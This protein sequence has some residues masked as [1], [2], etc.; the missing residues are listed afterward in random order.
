MS[1]VVAYR[2]KLIPVDLQ[3]KE[4][5]RWIQDRLRASFLPTDYGS[6]LEALEDQYYN[7]Y[8]YDSATETLYA[9]ERQPL[10]PETFVRSTRNSDGSYD[11][12]LS[13]HSGIVGFNE[14]AESILR[15]A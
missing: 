12:V 14:V 1:K 15:P 5:D 3:G 6:W 4:L 7:G 9:V 13:Y 8:F 11:F 10:Y 2:G